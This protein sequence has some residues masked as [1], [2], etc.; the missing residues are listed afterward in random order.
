MNTLGGDRMDFRGSYLNRSKRVRFDLIAEARGKTHRAQHA[1]LIFGK[2]PA[3]I[4]D[5]SDQGGP[6][7][8]LTADKVE[9]LAGVVPHQQAVDGEV[10]ARDI[11]FR[12]CGV[13]DRVGVP[14]VGVTE[15]AAKG[16]DLDL[17][18]VVRNEN[19]AEA[20]AY[21]DAVRKEL[22][23]TLRGCV[24]GDIVIGRRPAEQQIADAA[25]NQEG[26]MAVLL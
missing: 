3:R 9:H 11:V 20:R 5:G 7:V 25:A 12:F 19:D 2:A 1:Q 13:R 10:A 17:Q 21:G 18:A 14:P 15:V 22:R 26:P 24:R 16:S 23:N 4:A 8:G 6:E